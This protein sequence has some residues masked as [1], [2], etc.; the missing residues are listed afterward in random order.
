MHCHLVV[1]VMQSALEQDLNTRPQLLHQSTKLGQAAD[2]CCPHSGILQY[3][4]V[5][6]VADVLGGLLGA[7][8]LYAQQVQHLRGQVCELAVLWPGPR[9]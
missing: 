4:A 8:P 3:D 7:R 5:V 1:I 9:Q 2:S 6:D